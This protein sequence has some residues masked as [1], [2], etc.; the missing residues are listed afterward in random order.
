VQKNPGVT[1]AEAKARA[2]V[3][4]AVSEVI[5]SDELAAQEGFVED[6]ATIVLAVVEPA[7]PCD[8]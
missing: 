5:N 3:A 7:S 4:F 2:R 1:E 6:L 8:Q